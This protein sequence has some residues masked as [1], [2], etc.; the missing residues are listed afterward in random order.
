MFPATVRRM[1]KGKG[2]RPKKGD[3]DGET[4]Q[5][6]VFKDLAD[7]LG[8]IQRLSQA[9]GKDTTVAQIIDPLIRAEVTRQYEPFRE[10]AEKIKKLEGGKG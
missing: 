1:P 4:R 2:G 7:M 9:D 5:I 3:G 8:W 6:R 10:R